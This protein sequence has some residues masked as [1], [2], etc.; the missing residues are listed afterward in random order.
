MVNEAVT[1]KR[2]YKEKNRIRLKAE[3]PVYPPIYTQNL[4][5]LGKLVRIIRDYEA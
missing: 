1:L 5:I 3:N 4:Q 2:F